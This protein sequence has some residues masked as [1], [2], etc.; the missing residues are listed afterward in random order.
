MADDILIT[1]ESTISIPKIKVMGVGGGGSNAVSRMYRDRLPDVDYIVINTDLQALI[2]SDVPI[3]LQIGAKAA[4]GLG[5]GG[6][7]DKGRECAEE[8]REGLKKSL[9]G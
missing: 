7:P 1:Q 2:R 5:A 3:R 9:E 6:D 4:R 8:S